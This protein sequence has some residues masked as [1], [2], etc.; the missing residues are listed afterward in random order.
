MSAT[1]DITSTA[2]VWLVTAF[3]QAIL[4]GCGLLQ[5]FL[6]FTWYPRDPWSVK[7]TV[8]TIVVLQCVQI[9]A[10]MINVYNWF[11]TGFGD[12]EN[13]N[14]IHHADMVQLVAL[15]L[16]IFVAQA[17]FARSIFKLME[18]N[19]ILPVI[20]ALCA[21]TA[22]GCGIGQVI[23]SISLKYY[24]NMNKTALTS[25][26]QSA[27]ALAADL[28]ITFGLC[29]RLNKGRT[30]MQSSNRI[31]NFL[32]LTAINR[33]VFTM[34][35][36]IVEIILFLTKPGT[37]Y[38][39]IGFLISDKLYMNSLLA[40]LNTRKYANDLRQPGAQVS[41]SPAPKGYQPPVAIQRVAASNKAF[42]NGVAVRTETYRV[43]DEAGFSDFEA[44]KI[45]N[46]ES[47]MKF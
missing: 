43:A 36:A 4:Q 7:A 11:I 32:V 31:I 21:L 47:Y 45:Q 26:L 16:S 19:F 41:S 9:S 5:V 25:N 17:H 42:T 23:Q 18:R 24:S 2:G 44:R 20:I 34:I 10:A 28:L 29:W 12:Y 35:F 39:M 8:I 40:I 38:F 15:F 33:G 37:F 13:L 30:G 14:T 1:P 22:L 6:Y 27:F 3:V 46:D